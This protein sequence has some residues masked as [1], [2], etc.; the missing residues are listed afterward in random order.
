MFLEEIRVMKSLEDKGI[1]VGLLDY[2]EEK[3]RRLLQDTLAH[4]NLE[5]QSKLQ[6]QEARKISLLD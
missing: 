1:D 5:K 6:A 4:I 3:I 2:D